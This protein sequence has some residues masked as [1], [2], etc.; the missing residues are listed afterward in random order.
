VIP[1]KRIVITLAAVI[2]GFFALSFS[3][4]AARLDMHSGIVKAN[5]PNQMAYSNQN[6]GGP[7][8]QYICAGDWYNIV[9]VCS[10]STRYVTYPITVH[11]GRGTITETHYFNGVN[12]V[13]NGDGSAGYFSYSFNQ[14]QW[15]NY[16]PSSIT[17]T[18][19][20]DNGAT[21]NGSEIFVSNNKG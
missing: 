14:N 1:I 21:D 20:S 11:N 13:N 6:L 18:D 10:N 5:A 12:F 8:G 2:C 4:Q 7:L 3:A 9:Q 15:Y 17:Y 16:L 19:Y